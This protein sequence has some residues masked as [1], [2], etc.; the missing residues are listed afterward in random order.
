VTGHDVRQL[1]LP[2][3]LL[4]ALRPPEDLTVSQWADRYRILHAK[5]CA[6]PGP[7]RT[8]RV[9]YLREIQD[10]FT[11]AGVGSIIFVK[12]SRVG[13]TEFLNNVLGFS[14]DQRPMPT[15][16][17]LPREPDV[18]EEFTGRIRRIFETSPKLKAHC[19]APNWA[20][21]DTIH[22]DAM[23]IMGAWASSPDT[24]IRRT[25]GVN[26]FDEVDNCEAHAGRLGNI[27]TLLL[28]RLTTFGYRGKQ[29][30]VT[31]PTTSDASGWRAWLASDQRKYWVPCP[32][33]GT[34][35]LLRFDRIRF[36]TE[37]SATPEWIE[38]QEAAWYQCEG[39]ADPIREPDKHWM[40]LRG[41]WVPAAQ[42]VEEPLDV[43]DEDLV[44]R[45]A[46]P[47][48]PERWRP[49]LAGDAPRTR[50]RGYWLPCYYSPW[51]TFSAILAK[52]LKVKD[53][54]AALRVVRNQWFAEPWEE[55]VHVTDAGELRK[56]TFG[57]HPADRVP[58]KALVLLAGAD[59]Q[60]DAIYYVL[61]AYGEHEESWKVREGVCGD[62]EE[63]QRIAL[64][65]LF[66]RVDGCDAPPLRGS[67]LAI[68]SGFRTDEVYDFGLR[69]DPEVV[70]VKG[71]QD[72]AGG[73]RHRP[74]LIDYYPNG[75]RNPE[76]VKLVHVNTG[77]FKSKLNR[78]MQTRPGD[79]GAWH[80]DADTSDEY[81]RH[82]TAEHQVYERY[83]KRRSGGRV[84][85]KPKAEGRPN[86]WFDC[87]VYLA[88]LAD[89]K[90]VKSLREGD[91]RL[92]GAK[93]LPA[94]VAAAD[95]KPQARQKWLGNR[96][97]NWVKR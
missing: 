64:F 26:A 52:F 49:S 88:A 59:V 3:A 4:Q 77:L 54:P 15:I 45:A 61:R 2:P 92:Q 72:I 11:D 46:V 62:F 89:M 68:D 30:G 47:Y 53:D 90:D 29:I 94:G 31:T 17:V 93:T 67:Y 50:Q 78:L 37:G 60:A 84:L 24:M 40:N 13:G 85:W 1:A 35:Q 25:S 10:A 76:G 42:Q 83:G 38:Q 73:L 97:R 21:D 87:E 36:P 44:R 39:C 9:P 51:R 27:W 14:A 91:Q 95:E 20:T 33:C 74:T 22:L 66:D 28:E 8:D 7:W 96:P 69:L 70:I 12:S 63:L 41:L 81:L 43:E 75:R 71:D 58:A 82:L 80:L 86:H 34:Y 5:D 56:K 65:T 6:E 55:A 16:Y 23:T 32:R 57:A 79:R 48:G 19:V 18:N